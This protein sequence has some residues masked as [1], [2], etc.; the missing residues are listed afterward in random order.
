MAIGNLP[1]WAHKMKRKRL[2]ANEAVSLLQQSSLGAL[3]R[4]K[5]HRLYDL[6]MSMKVQRLRPEVRRRRYRKWYCLKKDMLVR[7]L[8]MDES[9]RII[10][11]AL[12][13][14]L[15]R[16]RDI[17]IEQ[18]LAGGTENK[19]PIC[20]M[21]LEGFD[22]AD[23][24]VHDNIVFCKQD[25]ITHISTGCNFTNPITRKELSR[26]A[27]ARLVCP[28][29]L[30]N[31]G[32]HRGLRRNVVDSSTHFF[33]ENDIVE[34]YRELLAVVDVSGTRMF[35]E[36]L[37]RQLYLSF[38]YKLRQMSGSEKMRTVCVLKGLEG[39]PSAWVT[40]LGAGAPVFFYKYLDIVADT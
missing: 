35:H 19:C 31:Y 32:R 25:M 5:K 29:L 30:E 34:G 12:R 4:C 6:H 18:K 10:V 1:H 27:V 16:K 14:V 22:R 40:W 28:A 23:L 20:L 33:M 37:F 26:D 7:A 11:Q 38:E 8:I 3:M 15:E 39:R 13:R 9:V 17:F 2:V 21:P 24:F 36:Q